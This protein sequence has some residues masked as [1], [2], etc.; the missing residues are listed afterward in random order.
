MGYTAADTSSFTRDL[1]G[2]GRSRRPE[3]GPWRVQTVRSPPGLHPCLRVRAHVA[4]RCSNAC[5]HGECPGR[6]SGYHLIGCNLSRARTPALRLVRSRYGGAATGQS[7]GA[8]EADAVSVKT[9]TVRRIA[10]QRQVDMSGTLISPHQ[11]KIS[12]E[13]AGVVRDVPRAAR[14]GRACQAT[15]SC[16]IG[17]ARA[18]SR[19]RARGERTAADRGAARD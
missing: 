10:V 17:N 6:D 1:H 14:N 15:S 3:S 12:S 4:S 2:P 5:R 19:P 13:V 8:K 18:S 16:L 7:R 11:A 9:T